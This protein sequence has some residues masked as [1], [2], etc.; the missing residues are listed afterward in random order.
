LKDGEL[1]ISEMDFLIFEEVHNIYPESTYE[2]IM[3]NFIFNDKLKLTI[4]NDPDFEQKKK[5]PKVLAFFNLESVIQ[6]T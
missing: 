3:K 5:L 4:A 6:G 1:K 2:N